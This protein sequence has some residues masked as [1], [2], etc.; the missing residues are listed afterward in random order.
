M[1]QDP[2]SKSRSIEVGGD[3]MTVLAHD[4]KFVFLSLFLDSLGTS[5]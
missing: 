2:R 3:A 4:S 1:S 5:H